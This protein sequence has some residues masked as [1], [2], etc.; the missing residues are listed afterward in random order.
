MNLVA[1]P[2]VFTASAVVFNN[3]FSCGQS[4]LDRP[5]KIKGISKGPMKEIRSPSRNIQ[6]FCTML[7]HLASPDVIAVCLSYRYTKAIWDPKKLN[8]KVLCPCIAL[9]Y[10][11]NAVVQFTLA[12]PGARNVLKFARSK[13]GIHLGILERIR[14]KKKTSRWAQQVIFMPRLDDTLIQWFTNIMFQT[15][16]LISPYP[17]PVFLQLWKVRIWSSKPSWTSP[18]LAAPPPNIEID[19]ACRKKTVRM[20]SGLQSHYQSAFWKPTQ[21]HPV[22]VSI[23]LRAVFWWKHGQIIMLPVLMMGH[24]CGSSALPPR[25]LHHCMVTWHLLSSYMCAYVEWWTP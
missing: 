23:Y 13:I 8:A 24:L 21:N 18:S 25:W 6:K 22:S 15:S 3:R 5:R 2:F 7:H 1:L 11:C 12:F 10:L 19:K 16:D 20:H 9:A 4:F 17:F 14:E